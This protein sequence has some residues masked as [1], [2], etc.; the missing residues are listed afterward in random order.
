[1]ENKSL[2]KYVSYNRYNIN[3]IIPSKCAEASRYTD[4]K[5]LSVELR[6]L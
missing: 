4:W 5:N 2:L 3:D 6:L 1:M